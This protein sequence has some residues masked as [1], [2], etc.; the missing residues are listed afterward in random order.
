LPADLMQK[1][2]TVELV[3]AFYAIE[4][5]NRR[6]AALNLIKAVSKPR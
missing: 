5:E 3:R 2:T 1:R 4:D 6:T